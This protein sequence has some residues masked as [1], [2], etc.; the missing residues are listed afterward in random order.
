MCVCVRVAVAGKTYGSGLQLF[1]H[2]HWQRL[3]VRVLICSLKRPYGIE[4][5]YLYV[6][7]YAAFLTP[8]YVASVQIILHTQFRGADC[9]GLQTIG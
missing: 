1:D 4:R 8:H 2:R 5:P 9:S 6:C 7:M 3:P